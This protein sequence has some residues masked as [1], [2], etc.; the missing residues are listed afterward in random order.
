MHLARKNSWLSI[1]TWDGAL[2][3]I[4]AAAPSVVLLFLPRN[5]AAEIA[6]VVF[7]PIAVALLR[8]SVG[9]RQLEAINGGFAPVSRQLALAVAISVLMLFEGLVG[10]C[11]FADDE[12]NS[13]L[14]VAA[15]IYAIYLAAILVALTPSGQ[16]RIDN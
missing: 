5:D 16:A 2:P 3:L 12:P 14:L 9:M 15:A 10:I 6:A 11:R 8:A 1:L 7:L 4:T 13:V